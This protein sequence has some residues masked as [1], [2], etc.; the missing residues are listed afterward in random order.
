MSGQLQGVRKSW[1]ADGKSDTMIDRTE[2]RTRKLVTLIGYARVSTLDRDPA[3][4]LDALAAAGCTK[5]FE[6]RASGGR[7]YQLGLRRALDYMREGDVLVVWKL[8]RLGRSLAHLLEPS[9]CSTSVV[10]ASVRLRGD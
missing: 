9:R 4:Q 2:R 10:W 5:V 8:D 7:A 1:A 3:L 6:D